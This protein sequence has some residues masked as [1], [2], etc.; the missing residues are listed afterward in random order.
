MSANNNVNLIGRLTKDIELR[1]TN[2]GKSVASFSLAVD[3]IPKGQERS[4]DFFT[5]TVWGNQAENMARY[6]HKGSL[7]AVHGRLRSGSYE[8]KQGEK[9]Y[10]VDVTA[11]DVKFLDSKHDEQKQE[12]THQNKNYGAQGGFS[13]QGG[14]TYQNGFSDAY[15]ANISSQQGAQNQA[16]FN[17]PFGGS[18]N[19][20]N[21]DYSDLPF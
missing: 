17:D 11:E 5:V 7:V 16:G 20:V 21:V 9:V 3:R 1:Q 6:C 8:N 14:Q 2:S 15:V 19:G 18:S 10:F 12:E 4:A 13:T